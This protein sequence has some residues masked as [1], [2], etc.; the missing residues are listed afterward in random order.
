M[1]WPQPTQSRARWWALSSPGAPEG[2]AERPVGG[3]GTRQPVGAQLRAG[4]QVGS[5]DLGGFLVELH[6][7]RWDCRQVPLTRRMPQ[8]GRVWGL[9]W[10]TQVDRSSQ[11]PWV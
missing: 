1:V 4:S 6:H 9:G 5:R 10:G 8:P 7:L 2:E 3:E 11:P